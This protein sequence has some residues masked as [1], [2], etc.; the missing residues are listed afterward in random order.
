MKRKNVSA[1]SK[2]VPRVMAIVSMQGNFGA[3]VM[4]GV[5]SH[6]AGSSDW[7][8]EIV[9]SSADFTPEKVHVA[10]THRIDGVLVAVNPGR[11]DSFAA[12]A[13]SGIPFV[14]VETYSPRL[15]ARKTGSV[16]VR[17]DNQAIGREAA[18][19]FLA[20]GRFA[21][22]AYI[23]HLPEREWSRL[24]EE[25]F[26]ETLSGKR[27][28]CETFSPPPGEDMD[29]VSMRG[30]LAKWLRRLPPPVALFVADDNTAHNVLQTCRTVHLNVPNTIA[31]LG[32]DNE[33]LIC[34]HTIPTLSSI[35]PDFEEAG[36]L[37]AESLDRLMKA[38]SACRA[39]SVM[40]F[41]EGKCETVLRSS[42][43]R[44]TTGGALVQ[45]ALTFITRNAK[46]GI[47]AKDVVA[48]LKVSRPLVDLRFRQV[49]GISLQNTI[50][51]ARLAELKRLLRETDD[52]IESITVRLGW[53]SPNY[54]K[55]LFR[56]RFGMSMREYRSSG[57]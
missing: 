50:I 9:R 38:R 34:E 37:A 21:T 13:A 1:V 46:R 24:R 20:Q 40:L 22:F 19:S 42:T 44:E 10:K 45:K 55:N 47:S 7:G 11:E 39:P 23:P 27:L 17:I 53:S 41:S 18:R 15:L 52:P 25:G 16:H 31:V 57:R 56:K 36:R 26:R 3:E 5:F 35:Q 43:S 6:L 33:T 29:P 30:H 2:R 54:P 51:E 28:Q 49:R 14:T 8:I 12:L 4:R 48:H 32:V